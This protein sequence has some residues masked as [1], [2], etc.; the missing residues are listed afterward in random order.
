MKVLRRNI[1]LLMVSTACYALILTST[2]LSTV[3]VKLKSV[4]IS[5]SNFSFDNLIRHNATYILAT[6]QN[7]F[8]ISLVAHEHTSISIICVHS[9]LKNA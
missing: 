6:S 5:E 8:D 4:I 7:D 1:V 9:G 3:L 2:V